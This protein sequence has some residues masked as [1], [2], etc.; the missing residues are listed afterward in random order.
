[1]AISTMNFLLFLRLLEGNVSDMCYSVIPVL[2]YSQTVG[3]KSEE[4]TISE[5]PIHRRSEI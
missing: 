5:K 1:M 2:P 3:K 4:P